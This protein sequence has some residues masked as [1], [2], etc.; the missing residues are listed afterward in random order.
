MSNAIV[1]YLVAN[2]E[3]LYECLKPLRYE[4]ARHMVVEDPIFHDEIRN[5]YCK[6]VRSIIAVEAS[7]AIA[8]DTENCLIILEGI[9]LNEYLK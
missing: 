2:K 8:C 3:Y 6:R 7:K 5:S 1:D 4:Y 9:D